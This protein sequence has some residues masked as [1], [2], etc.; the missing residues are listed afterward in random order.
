LEAGERGALRDLLLDHSYLHA[1]LRAT[2]VNALIA[3]GREKLPLITLNKLALNVQRVAFVDE[4]RAGSAP[5]ALADVNV[6]NKSPIELLGPDPQSR[7]PVDLL[8]TGKIDP[9]VNAFNVTMQVAPFAAQPTLQLK[10]TATGIN[11]AGLI[12]IAP[13]L[14]DK[15]DGTQL[16]DGR[17]TT[18]LEATA[19]VAKRGPARLDFSK[20][21]ELSAIVRDVA[22]RADG[23]DGSPVLAGVEEVRADG[24]RIDP[25][26]G[27]IVA[28]SID[29]AKPIARA[30]RES[31]GVHA[32]GLVVKLPEKPADSA[33]PVRASPEASIAS[34][35]STPQSTQ[36]REKPSAEI[37]IE[38]FTVS[39]ID[40]IV[41]D[42]AVAPP[43]IVPLT[44]LEMD[45]RGLSNLAMYESRPIRFNVTA[46][47]GKVPL[48]ADKPPQEIFAEVAASGNVTLYPHTAGWA[49]S[50]VS[51]FEL[52]S[53]KGEA[54]AMGVTI[55][56]GVMDSRVDVRFL[57]G[58]AIDMKSRI[59]FTDLRMSEEPGGRLGNALKL[60][61]P[62][63][64]TIVLLQDASGAITIPVGLKIEK[65]EIGGGQ[66]AGAAI[67]AVA[68]VIAT[69]IT[70]A[71]VKA[72]G[73]VTEVVGL[74]K[75]MGLFGKKKPVGPQDAGSLDY[76]AGAGE[77]TDGSANVTLQQV[78]D[79]MKGDK[80]LELTLKH[81]L[82][83]GDIARASQRANPSADEASAVG[84]YLRQRRVEL[85]A[86]REQ[87]ASAARATIV[88][89]A[90][91]KAAAAA[92]ERLREVESQLAATEDALDR[93]YELTAPG[94]ARQ[95]DRRT[96][97]ASL[98]IAE[99]R[100]NAIKQLIVAAGVP[101]AQNR[102]VV[103]KPQFTQTEGDA[104]GRVTMVITAKKK[105]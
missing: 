90:D 65:S 69:A 95:A 88:A 82:G 100:L 46:G 40:V 6:T 39:G 45:V 59:A 17:F 64:A 1:K 23:S 36:V 14:R 66:I 44:S 20:P 102:V 54:A 48:R 57:E 92:I 62:L 37:T 3:A 2:D 49:R 89:S 84:A 22:F 13:E 71:P 77:S 38:K 75:A 33:T 31:D 24:V 41:Q 11:G 72:V 99:A 25:A 53:I 70:N 7:P 34:S 104:G 73:A 93:V 42:N 35:T 27:S 28:R 19:K 12:A 80:T 16:I 51:G 105:V 18:S 81:E 9:V 68:S 60:A 30:T 63:D 8:V 87:V 96:R 15:I 52:V 85:I 5:I 50:T 29:V 10:L 97:T 83:G 78:I 47:A 91:K 21:M 32:L 56:N 55:D 101:D 74:N 58:G 79:Q 61:G 98:Q 94:A 103:T 67:G 76:F 43:T 86:Q 26:T 4:S